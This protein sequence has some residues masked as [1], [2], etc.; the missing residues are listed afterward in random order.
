VGLV[1]TPVTRV[2]DRLLVTGQASFV[3][4]LRPPGGADAV[5]VAFVRSPRAHA[6]IRSIDGAEARGAPG[7]VAVFTWAEVPIPPL[8]PSAGPDAMAQP[9]LA[10]DVVRYVGEPVAVIV[11]ETAASAEDAAASVLVDYDALPPVV[12]VEA[13][14][15]DDALLFPAAGSNVAFRVGDDGDGV[16]LFDHCEVVVTQQ[17]HNQRVAA[18]PLEP[19]SALCVPGADG[20]L[21]LWSSTQTPHGVRDDVVARLGLDV[22]ALRV[23]A[24]HVGGGFGAKIGAD[25]E[26]IVV[27]WLAATLGRPVKWVEARS[28]NLVCH[29]HARAQWQRATIGGRRDGTLIAYRLDITA[30][31]GAYPRVGAGLPG[32]TVDMAAGPYAFTRVAAVA[33]SVVTNTAPV[34][35][36]RGAGQP[37]ACAALERMV[38]LFAAEIGVD[39]A[40]VRARNLVRPGAFPYL[41]PSGTTYDSGDYPGALAAVCTAAGYESLRR[42][43]A[44][45]RAHGDSRHLGIGLAVYVQVSGGTDSPEQARVEMRADGSATAYVGTS[46]H[47]QGHDTSFAMLLADELGIPMERVVVVHGDTDLIASGAGTVGSRSLQVAGSALQSAAVGLRQ[48]GRIV[49]ARAL[50]VAEQDVELDRTSGRWH[51]RHDGLGLGWGELAVLHGVL[52]GEGK[53]EG[54]ATTPFGAHLAVVEVD[55]ETGRVDLFRYVAVDDAGRLL[56]PL[57]AEGQRHGGIAQGLGQGVF[58]AVVYDD[59]GNPLTA[60]LADYTPPGAPDLP[61]F[62]LVPMQT[63]SPVNPLGVKGIGEAGAIGAPP[64]VQNAVVDAVSHLGVR[65]IDMPLRPWKV[66]KAVR[67]AREGLGANASSPPDW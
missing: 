40:A 37:E 2:E 27:C 21:T 26:T 28:E 44:Q 42:E 22:A 50:G 31:A 66:W 36:Y 52:T 14:L 60:S 16:Q 65:H 9:C 59:D 15:R 38:D 30:D 5:H 57:I 17:L 45:R 33:R 4:N 64:A 47:G 43:Q 39:P 34:G 23:I 35:A 18:V 6:R 55:G 51:G 63:P 49:A 46:P 29:G 13:A 11:A 62:E 58:E 48:Q 53:F 7:V 41:S 67:D 3:D 20:R 32:V 25:A 8:P 1:G 61:S 10:V 12:S 19:R 54:K 56:N 24:P